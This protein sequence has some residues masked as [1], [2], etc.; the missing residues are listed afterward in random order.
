MA[1]GAAKLTYRVRHIPIDVGFSQLGQFLADLLDEDV[2]NVRACSLAPSLQV[3]ENPRS[4]VATI[5]FIKTPALLDADQK[6]WR[7]PLPGTVRNLIIDTHF[8]GLT[9]LNNVSDEEYTSTCIAIS[10]L[11][12]HP[13]GSWAQRSNFSSSLTPFMWLRDRIPK[14]IPGMR[15]V[16]YGYDTSLLNSQSFQTLHDLSQDFITTLGSVYMDETNPFV[17]LAHSLGGV[18]LKTALV[19]LRGYGESHQILDNTAMVVLFGVPNKGMFMSHLLAMVRGNPN[20]AIVGVLSKE[21]P[22]LIGLD[23]SFTS[24]MQNRNIR[25]VSAYETLRSQLA[26][27]LGPGKWSRTGDFEVLVDQDSAIQKSSSSYDRFPINED[28]SNLVKFGEGDRNCDRLMAIFVEFQRKVQIQTPK[29]IRPS[30][31]TVSEDI[32]DGRLQYNDHNAN[33][34]RVSSRLASPRWTAV[35]MT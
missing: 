3:W 12:S 34:K 33:D 25:V 15:V 5:T 35:S 24:L 9:P 20:E 14:D 30:P 4:S 28:H 18:I 21:N 29:R 26:K 11:G 6:E 27:E 13:C 22:K 17:F 10:G 2:A 1:P 16:V 32:K 8:L 7:V 23:E 31:F 19:N